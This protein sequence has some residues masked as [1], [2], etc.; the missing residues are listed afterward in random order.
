MSDIEELDSSP[1]PTPLHYVGE[2]LNENLCVTLYVWDLPYYMRHSW[3][4]GSFRLHVDRVARRSGK[5]IYRGSSQWLLEGWLPGR[6][7]LADSQ[8]SSCYLH[9]A[10]HLGRSGIRLM[11]T[12]IL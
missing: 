9:P 4:I 7:K 1:I 11:E 3:M 6:D 2:R 5:Q 12:S 8:G 10:R